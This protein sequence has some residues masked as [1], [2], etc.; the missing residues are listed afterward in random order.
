MVTS[1][2]WEEILNSAKDYLVELIAD[3]KHSDVAI[4]TIIDRAG[5]PYTVA[6]ANA[7]KDAFDKFADAVDGEPI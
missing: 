7:V 4:A 3:E 2:T 5:V 6:N 1:E